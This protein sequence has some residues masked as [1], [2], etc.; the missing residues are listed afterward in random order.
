MIGTNLATE[1]SQYWSE[2]L[3]RRRLAPGAGI[4]L[5]YRKLL[6]PINESS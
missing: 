5:E 1:P 6:I 4:T 2:G 3:L